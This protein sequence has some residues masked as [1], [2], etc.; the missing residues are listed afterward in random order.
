MV[1][2]GNVPKSCSYYILVYNIVCC[3]SSSCTYYAIFPVYLSIMHSF[4]FC[5]SFSQQLLSYCLIFFHCR[6]WEFCY[7]PWAKQPSSPCSVSSPIDFTQITCRSWYYSAWIRMIEW[8]HRSHFYMRH[9]K[10]T[11]W[12]SL[13]RLFWHWVYFHYGYTV[14]S[15]LNMLILV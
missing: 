4:W 11:I 8:S 5:H 2:K 12:A 7:W 13:L 15:L 1:E 6:Q 14:F 3:C 9:R 10:Q